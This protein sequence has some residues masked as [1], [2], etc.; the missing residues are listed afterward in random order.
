[1]WINDGNGLD[2]YGFSTK[3]VGEMSTEG[4][5]SLFGRFGSHFSSTEKSVSSA[6]NMNMTQTSNAVNLRTNSKEYG[7]SLRCVKQIE[8]RY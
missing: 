3:P 4:M 6:L 5:F 8:R 2:S 7:F 1:M